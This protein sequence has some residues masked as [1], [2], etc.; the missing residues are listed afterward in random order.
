MGRSPARFGSGLAGGWRLRGRGWGW[1]RGWDR[2]RGRLGRGGGPGRL[3]AYVSLHVLKCRR[4]HIAPFGDLAELRGSTG[5][6]RRGGPLGLLRGCLRG[7]LR[8]RLLPSS[9][10]ITLPQGCQAGFLFLGEA[11]L[12]GPGRLRQVIATLFGLD[13]GHLRRGLL[14]GTAEQLRLMTRLGFTNLGFVVLFAHIPENSK[15]Y[16]TIERKCQQ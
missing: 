3:L 8:V 2:R 13:T 7:C 10:L 6:P 12:L 4:S 11:L 15:N 1:N 14:R 5:L 9:L 16:S